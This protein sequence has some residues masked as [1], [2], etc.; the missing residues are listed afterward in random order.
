MEDIKQQLCTSVMKGD[1]KMAEEIY[2]MYCEPEIQGMKITLLGD[3]AL[4]MAVNTNKWENVKGLLH[5]QSSDVVL[6]DNNG[7]TPLHH[8]A[9]LGNERMC[10]EIALKQRDLLENRNDN[11]ETPLFMA[12]QHGQIEAFSILSVICCSL[13][14]GYQ[15]IYETGRR[16]GDG[17]TV[18]HC[19]IHGEYFDLAYQIIGRFPGFISCVDERG[20]SAIHI[21]A[22]KPNAFESSSRLT[23]LQKFIYSRTDHFPRPAGHP[24]L[25]KQC[26]FDGRIETSEPTRM[27]FSK[28]TNA[29]SKII[30]K[31]TEINI[32]ATDSKIADLFANTNPFKKSVNRKPPVH[33]KT[34]SAQT[35]NHTAGVSETPIL[36]AAKNGISELVDRILHDFPVAIHDVNPEGKNLVLLAVEN[37]QP[38]IIKTLRAKKNFTDSLLRFVDNEGNNALHYAATYQSWVAPDAVLQMQWEIKWYLFI[39]ETTPKQ[40]LASENKKGETPE[41]I[42]MKTHSKLVDL[43]TNWL[44]KTSESCTLVATL[45]ATV[46][47]ATSA[48]VPGGVEGRNGEPVLRQ[49]GMFEV[50]AI[51]SLVALCFSCTSAIMFLSILTSRHQTMDFG[52]DLPRKLLIGLTALFI[53]IAS[54]LASFCG[55]HFFIVKDIMRDAR[56][57]EY[58]VVLIPVGFFLAAQF[59]LYFKLMLDTFTKV[60]ERGF[61]LAS[62]IQGREAPELEG[63]TSF[64]SSPPSSTPGPVVPPFN[65]SI[66]PMS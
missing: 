20:N 23:W 10:L 31:P 66:E 30:P 65:I 8:A 48:S 5:K 22:S 11:N 1:W 21:L 2:G 14:D 19:A 44:M 35:A 47:F 13:K 64:N 37:R 27:V 25:Y 49:Q 53:S 28:S 33:L 3:T 34:L 32:V 4:H 50:F 24:I 36:M 63:Q 42:F 61:M 58:L 52:T 29:S 12:A 56:V 17:K 16:A 41:E 15:K 51:A 9:K 57:A 26:H 45:I 38:H 39:K 40:L 55:G 43:D 59:P 46:A 6:V 60:P 54:M 62:K 7:N 18:L